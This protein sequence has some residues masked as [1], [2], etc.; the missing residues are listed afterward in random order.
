M[1]GLILICAIFVALSQ[2]EGFSLP[3]TRVH[4]AIRDTKSTL[5]SRPVMANTRLELSS[6][7]IIPNIQASKG[8][9]GQLRRVFRTQFWK[10]FF[11]SV[12]LLLISF[13]SKFAKVMA[14]TGNKMEE[15]WLQRG[16]GSAI[17]R[18]IEIWRFA[19]VFAFKWV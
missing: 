10:A 3:R 14:A 1:K 11:A 17:G 5:K 18:T 12:A 8:F 4:V 16:Q 19:I 7:S 9:V 2:V 6:I 13:R 15:G